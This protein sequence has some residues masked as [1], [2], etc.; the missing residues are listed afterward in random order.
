MYVYNVHVS[1]FIYVYICICIYI[2]MFGPGPGFS[3]VFCFQVSAPPTFAYAARLGRWAA[4][5]CCVSKVVFTTG[6]LVRH[7]AHG[8]LRRVTHGRASTL[9]SHLTCECEQIPRLVFRDV[10]DHDPATVTAAKD[11]TVL[12]TSNLNELLRAGAQLPTPH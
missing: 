6:R 7:G 1:I 5:R 2:Y 4:H 10:Q 8:G 9:C 11:C 3:P 12:H